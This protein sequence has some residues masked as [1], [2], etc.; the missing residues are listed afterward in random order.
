MLTPK[1]NGPDGDFFS[2]EPPRR[3]TEPAGV[4]QRKPLS[5]I[6]REE[7]EHRN[8]SQQEV[9]KL[10]RIPL[11]YLQLLEGEGD[12]RLVP[13][14]LYLIASLRSYAAFLNIDPGATLTRFIAELE[15]GAA[16]EENA[17]GSV[18]PTRS[19]N[20][21]PQLRSWVFPGTLILLLPLGILAIVGYYSEP[22]QGPRPK[23]ATVAPFPSPSD[24]LPALQS[25]PLP[26]SASPAPPVSAPEADQVP[27]SAS[28]SAESPP[29]AV[30]PQA[31]PS[32]AAASRVESPGRAL[33]RLG[34]Q[35]T[36]KT[37]LHVTIDD[38]PMKRLF[39]L[40]GQTVEWSA[41]RGFT[42]SLGNAGG[43]KLTLDGQALPPL[44]K[45]GQMVRN[46]RLPSP[47]RSQDRQGRD[48]ARPRVTKSR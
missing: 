23:E 41:E 32:T 9:A 38:Q 4:R 35:A 20:S 2:D 24:P 7:R 46:I 30:A 19:L 45:A 17:G 13:D 43:V 10:T 16:V 37:W 5:Q 31:E 3:H 12:E 36:A 22:T 21:F 6:L 14:S 11:N 25:E 47:K 26:P 18:R 1:T 27:P 48:A 39:L 8:V 44:G 40:P 33:H 42:L 28:P 29:V 34:V 15:Q